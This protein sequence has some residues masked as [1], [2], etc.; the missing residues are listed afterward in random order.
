MIESPKS[1]LPAINLRLLID[2]E[3]FTL[4][5]VMPPIPGDTKPRVSKTSRLS[6]NTLSPVTYLS[7]TDKII[8]ELKVNK[9]PDFSES[10]LDMNFITTSSP[11]PVDSCRWSMLVCVAKHIERGTI[12]IIFSDLNRNPHLIAG[13]LDKDLF[14]ETL[15]FV[16]EYLNCL[17]CNVLLD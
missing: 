7:I 17:V 5:T 6:K 1:S 2:S 11:N 12:E 9:Y 16:P 15:S 10:L 13:T 4:K 14:K 8:R 3:E